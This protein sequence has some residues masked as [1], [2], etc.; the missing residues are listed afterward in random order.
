MRGTL[1]RSVFGVAVVIICS[2]A[3][4]T[5]CEPA[6][7]GITTVARYDSAGIQVV[8]SEIAASPNGAFREAKKGRRVGAEEGGDTSLFF[9][10]LKGPLPLERGGFV[11]ADA[12]SASIRYFTADFRQHLRIGKR[13]GGPGEFSS[14]PFALFKCNGDSI[15]VRESKRLSLFAPNGSY[16]SG[17]GVSSVQLKGSVTIVGVARDC[18]TLIATETVGVD[19]ASDGSISPRYQVVAF[20]GQKG[21]LETGVSF[22]GARGKEIDIQGRKVLAKIPWSSEGILAVSPSFIVEGETAKAELRVRSHDG[23]IRRI[24]RWQSSSD[25][26]T[27][28][29]LRRFDDQRRK[30]LRLYPEETPNFPT[31]SQLPIPKSKP[32]FSRV[33]I[34]ADSTIWVRDYSDSDAGYPDLLQA[35]EESSTVQWRVFDNSGATSFVVT[36]LRGFNPTW[37]TAGRVL[38]VLVD[39]DGVESIAEFNV[40]PIQ[41]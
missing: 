31:S 35:S 37:A 20:V 40:G 41:R 39:Q 5:G 7:R 10:G 17:A 6:A 24:I 33:L 14:G 32:L 21:V 2:V 16:I 19:T 36:L 9:Q 1:Q 22:L 30:F 13:G 28:D 11:I 29:D 8:L 26:I 3:M 18:G 15:V 4:N 23:S 38:G 27:S 34:G 25:P 12:S